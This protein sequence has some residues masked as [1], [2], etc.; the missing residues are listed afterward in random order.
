RRVGEDLV[1]LRLRLRLVVVVDVLNRTLAHERARQDHDADETRRFVGRSL[2]EHRIGAALVPGAARAVAGRSAVRVD[3]DA[4]VDQA[5][6][7]RALVPMQIGAAAGREG[8]AV[9][10]HQELAPR[11]R[12]EIGGQLLVRDHA[13]RVRRGGALVAARQFPAPD[14]DAGLAGLHRHGAFALPGVAARHSLACD[15]GAAVYHED[16][17]R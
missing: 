15:G 5:A 8:D 13:W 1:L 17:A 2:R 14:G 3:A 6:D 4:A 10:A 9:A 12:L 11:Q 16:E 7:A